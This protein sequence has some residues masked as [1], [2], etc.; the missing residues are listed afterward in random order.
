MRE[1]KSL[2]S[3]TTKMNGPLAGLPVCDFQ[4]QLIVVVVMVVVVGAIRT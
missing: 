2:I 1:I 4:V 3:F